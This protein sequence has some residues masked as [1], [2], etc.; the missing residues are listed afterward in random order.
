MRIWSDTFAVFIT[1]EATGIGSLPGNP[2][3]HFE[4]SQNY[5]NPFNPVT[6]IRY[7]L[8]ASSQIDL[9]IYNLRGQKVATLISKKQPAGSY[10]VQWDAN[11]FA[12][13]VYFYELKTAQGLAQTRKMVY[14]R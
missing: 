5:P 3:E 11:G 13:G 6:V 10:K 9:S 4:L 2:V 12:S 8:P 7:R 14:L 1:K